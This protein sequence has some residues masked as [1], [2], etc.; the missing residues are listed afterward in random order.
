VTQKSHNSKMK[1]N[2]NPKSMTSELRNFLSV[3]QCLELNAR[4]HCVS[5]K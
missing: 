5:V 2:H 1:K 4:K 3:P